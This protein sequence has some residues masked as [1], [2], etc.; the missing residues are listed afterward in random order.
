[1]LGPEVELRRT[2]YDRE[3]AAKHIR[4]KDWDQA[5][6]FAAGNVLSAPSVEQGMEFMGKMEARQAATA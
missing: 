4:A 5:E 1:M 3:A 6:E 2:D